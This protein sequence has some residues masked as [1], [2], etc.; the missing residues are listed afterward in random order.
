ME[1]ECNCYVC[2][3]VHIYMHMYIYM[4]VII[5]FMHSVNDTVLKYVTKPKDHITMHAMLF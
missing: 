3:T 2:S 4:Y 5:N 1:C